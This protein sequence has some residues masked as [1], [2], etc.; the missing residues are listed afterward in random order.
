MKKFEEAYAGYMARR[1][2]QEDAALLLNVCPRTFRRYL[3]RYEENGWEGLLDRRLGGASARRAPTDEVLE[4]TQKYS[5]RHQG[6]MVKHFYAWYKNEGGTRSYTWVKNRLQEADL[7]K[8]SLGR[9]K[10]RKRRTRAPW[11]GMMLHQD[12]STHQWIPGRYW[13]LI[14][15]MDDATNEHYSMFFVKEEG[16]A[17]SFVGVKEVIESRGLFSSLYTDRGSHY[18]HTA[19]AGGK[20]D[21]SQLTQFGRAMRQLNIQMIPAYSPQARGRSERMFS[22]HQSRIPKEL[23]LAG[24][25]DMTQANR[26]IKEQYLP[27]FNRE[28]M[29]P[30]QEEG[31]AF[32]RNVYVDID[33][34]LCEQHPR[35]VGKDNCVSF[36][37]LQL[38]IPSVKDRLH[39]VKV[40]VRVHRYPDQRLSIFHGPRLLAR[41]EPD[42][43][44]AGLELPHKEMKEQRT[45]AHQGKFPSAPSSAELACATQELKV[46]ALRAA[47]RTLSSCACS[48]I[49]CRT[50]AAPR[51]IFPESDSRQGVSPDYPVQPV[52]KHSRKNQKHL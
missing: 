50:T 14:V 12:G 29:Q 39:F 8:K 45:Q 21:R 10:H 47:S 16:T 46:G 3:A 37:G 25:T 18:W 13:D 30:A 11:P 44:P 5:S 24:I 33:D 28:F 32:V 36:E 23:A 20:V 19:Q 6:W 51:E 31:S 27:A 15:T 42:G 34:I 40:E 7:V 1:L 35:T 17:S 22:T 38:Q 49:A 43:R 2:T 41:Y 52:S 4:L 48:G 26:Y 9:G